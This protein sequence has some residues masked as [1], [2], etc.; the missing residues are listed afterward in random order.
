MTKTAVDPGDLVD[1]AAFYRAMFERR[2][3]AELDRIARVK[4]FRERLI[5]DGAFRM[6]LRSDQAA[7]ADVF[8]RFQV[9]GEPEEVRPIWDLALGNRV[10]STP[11]L[12][13]WPAVW[14]WKGWHEDLLRYRDLSTGLPSRSCPDKRFVAWRDRQIKRAASEIGPTHASISHP[15]VAYELS[16]GCSI[17]CWFCGVSAAKFGGAVSFAE[18]AP[19]WR[20]IL[21]AM[22]EL[23]GPAARTGFCYWATDPSDNPEY[24]AF[25]EEHAAITGCLP[26]A[27]TAA[28]LRDIDFTR[29]LLR[30]AE[31]HCTSGTRFS[32]TT[33]RQ[34]HG[35]F[36]AFSAREL[37]GVELVMQ[38]KHSLM[39]KAVA[40]RARESGRDAA[41]AG[42]GEA[43]T[44]ACVSGFLVSLPDRTIRLISPCSATDRW[45]L[46]YRIHAQARF[47]SAASFRAEIERMVEA[48]MAIGPLASQELTIRGDLAVQ[49][50]GERVT[51]SNQH[52]RYE[53]RGGSCLPA[54]IQILRRGPILPGRLI[55]ELAQA[56]HDVFTS[57]AVLEDLFNQVFLEPVIADPFSASPPVRRVA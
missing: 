8:E 28:P 18:Q 31:R 42:L 30:Q 17:G 27:T 40:G 22:A 48:N 45:P 20:G 34:L 51:L 4:R 5:A 23:F 19:L 37:L 21:T 55:E 2:S 1:P 3:D 41:A 52:M 57:S 7:P 46:G 43:S 50:E 24:D 10:W 53:L 14:L 36:A 25:A 26:Q 35:I 16:R 39:P 15:L 47:D 38:M 56:G 11:E 33:L 6:A 9:P 29:R 32:V 49:V 44:I 13:A 54:L 12:Q